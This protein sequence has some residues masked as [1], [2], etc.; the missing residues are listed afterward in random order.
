MLTT[1]VDLAARPERTALVSIEWTADRAIVRDLA[2]PA[3]DTVIL[4][5]I[6]R[7]D[8]TGMDCPLGWPAAFVGFVAAHHTGHV[9]IPGD[10]P[11]W[12]RSLTLRR[13]DLVVHERLR[14]VPLSVS[15]DRI[16]HVALRCA[17]LL[18]RL[19]AA[20]RPVDRSGSGPVVEVYPAASLRCW[21]LAQPGYKQPARPEALGLLVDRLLAAAPWLD[22]AS[23]EQAIRDSHDVLDAVIAAMTARAAARGQTF[24][25]SEADLAAAR[26]EGWIAIPDAPVSQLR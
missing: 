21:G 19:D 23:Y 25:P 24:P 4:K 6:D 10:D 8:K 3:D 5:A 14:L 12:R 22:C 1:G 16:A 13:T 11:D 17:V 18:A 7:A 20:G 9:G 15:A 26:T 2:S